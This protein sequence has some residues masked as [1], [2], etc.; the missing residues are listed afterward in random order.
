MVELNKKDYEAD[1]AAYWGAPRDANAE[2]EAMDKEPRGQ[3]M[4]ERSV[5]PE[6]LRLA[7]KELCV[8]L[9]CGGGRYFRT[10]APHFAAL[11]GIDFSASNLKVAEA[12]ASRD[13]LGNVSLMD[14][15]LDNI[16]GIQDASVDF[17]YSVA[18][19]MH[20]PNETKSGAF[21]E[22]ARI[23]KP[24]GIAILLE[25]VPI[26]AGDFDCPDI[27][28]EEWDF[29]IEEAGLEIVSIE[30]AGSFTKYKVKKKVS[31]A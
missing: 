7:S 3:E 25:I 16:A 17:V 5:L 31:H 15:S 20:M 4:F 23:L 21:R 30:E 27:E 1:P 26:F 24:D 22:L 18:V 13:G 28:S 9:G 11:I 19:F 2:M 12:I 14:A 10:A 29:R 6:I 8:D